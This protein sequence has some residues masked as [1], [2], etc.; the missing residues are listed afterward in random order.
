[1]GPR[2]DATIPQLPAEPGQGR[3]SSD[4]ANP[5]FRQVGGA[6]RAVALASGCGCPALP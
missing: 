5:L 6:E 3:L 1:M 2:L 4:P